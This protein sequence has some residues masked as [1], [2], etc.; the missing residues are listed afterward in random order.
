MDKTKMN[1]DQLWTLIRCCTCT[2][3]SL[4]IVTNCV[5]IFY[6]PLSESLGTGRGQIAIMATI[7]SIASAFAGQLV[8]RLLKRVHIRIIMTSGVVVSAIGTFLLSVARSLTA[9]YAISVFIG[10]SLVFYSTMTVSVV[11]NS[12]F[13]E[14]SPAKLGITMA[15]SGLVAAVMNPF[16]TAVMTRSG[17]AAAYRIE[18]VLILVMC[19]PATLTIKMG[20]MRLGS[21]P[22]S[23]GSKDS[24]ERTVIPAMLFVLICIMPMLTSITTGMNTHG[25]AHVV[26]LGYSLG[27][28]ATV[29]AFQSIFNSAWK[30]LFG[31]LAVRMGVIRCSI[32]YLTIT[33]IGSL[34]L[35]LITGV[36]VLIPVFIS[37]YASCFS[38]STIGVPT[39]VQRIAKE[40]YAEVYATVAMIQ[41]IAYALFTS[42][43]GT[44][45][46][47]AGNYVPCFL[48]VASCSVLGIILCIVLGKKAKLR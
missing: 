26:T 5:G 19:L 12:W 38:T 30:L 7:F 16:L 48:L 11:L 32:L 43:Y 6:T 23:P 22:K 41:S 42:F 20:E 46:D 3:C 25:A 13:G 34:A 37:L 28:G 9:L 40:R 24:A 27:F 18:A 8:A 45:S 17:Y 31:V 14:K 44:I 33:G 10:T 4:G 47:K 21:A 1:R 15:M 36:P 39:I 2:G 29:V 35:A